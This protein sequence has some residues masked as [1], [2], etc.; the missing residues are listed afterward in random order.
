[1]VGDCL[2]GNLRVR[3]TWLYLQQVIIEVYVDGQGFFPFH[4]K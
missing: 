4:L 3:P 2:V 1:M